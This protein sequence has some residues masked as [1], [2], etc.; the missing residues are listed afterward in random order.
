MV[1]KQVCSFCRSEIDYGRG[2]MRVLNDGTIL[3]FCSMKCKKS[4]L[5][6]KRDARKTKWTKIYGTQ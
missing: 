4:L 2:S 6:L 3:T 1:K 5:N